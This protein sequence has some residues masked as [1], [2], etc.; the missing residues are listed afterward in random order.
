MTDKT[1][2]F[3]NAFFGEILLQSLI[4]RYINAIGNQWKS[5]KHFQLS[6]C[7]GMDNLN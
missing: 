6:V 4:H 2:T 3:L 5:G 7:A 1:N